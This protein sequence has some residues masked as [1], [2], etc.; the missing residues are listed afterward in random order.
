[1]DLG[2]RW[3]RLGITKIHWLGFD[4]GI[5][6]AVI[7]WGF[8]SRVPHVGGTEERTRSS[9]S[10]TC[11]RRIFR[12]CHRIRTVFRIGHSIRT[13]FRTCH[14]DANFL[15]S[16]TLRLPK[17]RGVSSSSLATSSSSPAGELLLP[18][19]GE[20]SLPHTGELLPYTGELHLP[21]TG[22][23]L[24]PHIGEIPL[25]QRRRAPPPPTPASSPSPHTGEIPLPQRRR[26]PPPPTPASSPSPHTGELPLPQRRQAPSPLYRRA[27]VPPTPASSS[28]PT[29]VIFFTHDGD[30]LH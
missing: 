3:H 2:L 15:Q 6:M 29:P 27:H 17:P 19:T 24:L 14:L 18:Y 28:S 8:W 5:W 16:V 10:T 4:L 7:I 13:T 25:P 22:E 9:C 23:L 26:A 11:G 30:L 21:H 1:M 12:I 20:L